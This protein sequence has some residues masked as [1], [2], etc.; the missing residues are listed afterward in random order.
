MKK[1]QNEVPSGLEIIIRVM[2][3]GE[4]WVRR[5][6]WIQL[7]NTVWHAHSSDYV[8]MRSGSDMLTYDRGCNKG[9][10]LNTL[11]KESAET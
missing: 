4:T 8:G 7:S 5:A 6:I 2:S 3:D 11:A 10:Y 1:M 9:M